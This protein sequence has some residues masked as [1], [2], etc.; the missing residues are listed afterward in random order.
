MNFNDKCSLNPSLFKINIENNTRSTDNQPNA[1]AI[2]NNNEQTIPVQ[3]NR[4]LTRNGHTQNTLNHNQSSQMNSVQNLQ[5]PHNSQSFNNN[6]PIR[7][8]SIEPQTDFLLTKLKG[9]NN[10]E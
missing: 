3:F 10:N 2:L 6:N 1:R 4:N 9:N 7:V 8:S 5:N